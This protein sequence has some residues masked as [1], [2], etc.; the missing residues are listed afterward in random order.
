LAKP[1]AN[2]KGFSKPNTRGVSKRKKLSPKK[3]G[4][5]TSRSQQG[6]IMSKQLQKKYL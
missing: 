5:M 1:I 4:S 2:F 6:R 3:M